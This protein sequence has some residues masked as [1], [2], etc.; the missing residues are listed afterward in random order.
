M[1]H[2]HLDDITPDALM[3]AVN[4]L[5]PKGRAELLSFLRAAALQVSPEDGETMA[6]IADLLELLLG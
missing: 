6:R 2:P 5:S 4:S 1:P 3:D